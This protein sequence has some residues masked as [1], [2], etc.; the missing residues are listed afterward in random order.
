MTDMFGEVDTPR[1][2]FRFDSRFPEQPSIERVGEEHGPGGPYVFLVLLCDA[3]QELWLGGRPGETAMTLSALASK[4]HV[5]PVVAASILLSLQR[6]GLIA[7]EGFTPAAPTRVA[8]PMCDGDAHGGVSGGECPTCG[9]E[10]RVTVGL[11]DSEHATVRVRFP[12][13]SNWTPKDKTAA[14]RKARSR[15]NQA[16]KSDVSRSVTI[17]HTEEKREEETSTPRA[18]TLGEERAESLC[19]LLSLLIK[20][21]DP[22]AKTDPGSPR[23][24][25]AIRLL[26]DR[27]GRSPEE[28]EHVI[29]WCQKDDFW[30]Q[31]I[32]SAPKLRAKFDQLYAKAGKPKGNADDF[33]QRNGM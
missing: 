12:K 32:L 5:T 14:E 30:R 21:R 15:A 31:N 26:I 19:L 6:E 20:D 8:C 25:D 11:R 3:Y 33:F 1:R 10:G 13:W 29:R 17:G 28:V 22:H 7:L 4:A 2:W 24:L 27:D 16:L 23:W 18:N 9:G